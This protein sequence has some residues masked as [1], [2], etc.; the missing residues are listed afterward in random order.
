[1]SIF[2]VLPPKIQQKSYYLYNTIKKRPDISQDA[3]TLVG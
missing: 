3:T 2:T 1:M